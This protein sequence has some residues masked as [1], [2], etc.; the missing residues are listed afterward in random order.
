MIN[1]S[2]KGCKILPP[3]GDVPYNK[4]ELSK[5][6]ATIPPGRRLKKECPCQKCGRWRQERAVRKFQNE[7]SK[8]FTRVVGQVMISISGEPMNN[9]QSLPKPKTPDLL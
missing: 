2:F 1:R 6:I 8:A 9:P 5:K 3:G 4:D 7:M